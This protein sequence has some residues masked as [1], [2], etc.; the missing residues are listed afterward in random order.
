MN[1]A[2]L[3][4]REATHAAWLV[5]TSEQMTKREASAMVAAAAPLIAAQVAESIA[6]AIE[7]DL[8]SPGRCVSHGIR[9]GY[10]S[11]ARIARNWAAR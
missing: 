9:Y 8:N 11:A 3:D 6:R 5:S 7:A 1:P 10:E 2:D 4:L